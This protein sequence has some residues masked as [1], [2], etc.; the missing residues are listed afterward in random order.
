M[1]IKAGE[2]L[3]FSWLRHVQGCPIA[4]TNWKPSPTWPIRREPEP[5]TDFEGMREIAE[6]RLGF[7]VFKKSS[8][9]SSS[10]SRN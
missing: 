10:A 8:F 6:E 4:Q 3:I 7:E 1:K 9:N 5:T 2:S